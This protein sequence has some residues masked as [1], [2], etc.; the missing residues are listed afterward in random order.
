MKPT[1]RQ[2]GAAAQPGARQRATSV[3]RVASGRHANRTGAYGEV[4]SP[5]ETCSHVESV[6]ARRVRARRPATRAGPWPGGCRGRSSSRAHPS[7]ARRAAR[8]ACGRRGSGPRRRRAS[9]RAPAGTGACVTPEAQVDAAE[10]VRR[11][12]SPP[13]AGNR[14]RSRCASSTPTSATRRPSTTS[15]VARGWSGRSSPPSRKAAVSSSPGQLGAARCAARAAS[16][17]QVAGRVLGHGRVVVVRAHDER[18]GQRRGAARGRAAARARRRGCAMLSPVS[19]TR[20]G[21]S[22]ASDRD[23][24]DLAALARRQVQVGEVQDAQRRLTGGQHGH[25]EPPER[26]PADLDERRPRERA[27]ATEREPA[28]G[29]RRTGRHQPLP[30]FPRPGGRRCRRCRRPAGRRPGRAPAAA[31]RPA[32]A[33]RSRR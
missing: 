24:L 27:H 13:A 17:Q 14:S 10:P 6:A 5:A 20:C 32:A 28:E 18:T 9:R 16:R 15:D 30:P 22:A 29:P 23:P 25:G 2:R 33:A 19:I 11:V 4:P 21:S 3:S 7:P 26:E 1:V 12:A 31:D 8:R